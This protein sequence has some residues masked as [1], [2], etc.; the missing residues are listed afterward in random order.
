MNAVRHAEAQHVNIELKYDAGSIS[1]RVQDDGHGFSVRP[2]DGADGH[3]GL[4]SMQERAEAVGGHCR[5]NSV[6][7]GGT[8][9]LA[10]VPIGGTDRDG[11]G[12]DK[13]LDPAV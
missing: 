5:I 7:G 3:Y 10:V 2:E 1:L 11:L 13:S 4:K 8:E 9:V 6:D 12:M